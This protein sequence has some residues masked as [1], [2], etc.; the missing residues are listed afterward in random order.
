MFKNIFLLTFILCANLSLAVS[1]KVINSDVKITGGTASSSTSTGALVLSGTGGLGVGGACYVG[2]LGSFAGTTASTSN[3]TGT[4]LTAGGIAS[5]NTTDASS[6]T[7]GGTF[8]TA[9]GMAVAKKVFIGTNLAVAGT[10]TL[11]AS[12]ST[13]GVG[14]PADPGI[15]VAAYNSG[16]TGVNQFSFVAGNTFNSAAT[17][18]MSGFFSTVATQ[19]ASF[20][21]AD[22]GVKY[23]GYCSDITRTFYFGSPKKEEVE[24]Y[25]AVLKSQLSGL[26]AAKEGVLAGDVDLACRTSLGVLAEN[27]IHSTGHSV[28]LEI[29]D[30][31]VR[32][33]K[34][35]QTKLERNMVITVEPGVY[36]K[37]KFG[38]R[39]E[40]TVLVGKNSAA[41]TKFTKTLLK[42]KK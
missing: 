25:N 6:S 17:N 20:T 26:K 29:H 30:V 28:G 15:S 1:K 38:I 13:L 8:T 27:F 32:I 35:S 18:I 22:F 41:M 9:G 16:L 34:N 37:K 23:K 12:T 5:S 40:D 19:N 14:T 42:F 2:G 24:T 4:I 36:F 7:N 39:I 3:T 11:S 33:S 10:Q 21:T 31:G